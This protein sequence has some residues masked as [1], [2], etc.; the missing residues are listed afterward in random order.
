[1]APSRGPFRAAF[2]ESFLAVP[3]RVPV[4]VLARSQDVG[5][6]KFSESLGLRFSAWLRFARVPGTRL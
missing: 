1:M 4:R 2:A 3:V 6:K 5:F